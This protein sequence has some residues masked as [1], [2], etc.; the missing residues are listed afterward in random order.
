MPA[1]GAL[2]K[3]LVKGSMTVTRLE[4]YAC[5]KKKNHTF[6]KHIVLCCCVTTWKP[7]LVWNLNVSRSSKMLEMCNKHKVGQEAQLWG[8]FW[9]LGGK[10]RLKLDSCGFLKVD[11]HKATSQ[12]LLQEQ[13]MINTAPVAWQNKSKAVT[14][15]RCLLFY[16]NNGNDLTLPLKCI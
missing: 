10:G 16:Q 2:V 5:K 6:S 4:M 13:H 3:P 15:P 14:A 1:G 9:R 11:K 12:K 8:R 7:L